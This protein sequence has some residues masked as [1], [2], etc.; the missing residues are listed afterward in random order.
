MSLVGLASSG[1][2]SNG[3][4]LARKI[5]FEEQGL[6]LDAPF[7]GTAHSV[8]DELLTPT[9]IYV[10]PALQALRRFDITALCHITGGGLP[11]NLPRVL[12]AGCAAEVRLD[13]WAQPPVFR[14]LQTAGK[15]SDADMLRTFNCGVG[16]VVALPRSEVAELI[17][18]FE[19]A[20]IPSWEM[21]SIIE[22]QEG[23]EPVVF[24]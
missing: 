5:I 11:D 20:D 7:P 22:A 12:A 16:M 2:H 9:R 15:V 10:K 13:S 8:A 24:R 21:G 3:Y 19:A 18:H 17:A 6:S 23:Q 14:F 1:L 4:S